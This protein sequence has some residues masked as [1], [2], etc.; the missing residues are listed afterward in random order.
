MCCT[1]LKRLL[2]VFRAVFTISDVVIL[3]AEASLKSSSE[4]PIKSSALSSSGCLFCGT[5][6][7]DSRKRTSLK[8]KVQDL[9]ERVAI[10]LDINISAIHVKQYL[11]NNRCYKKIKRLEKLQEEEKLLKTELKKSFASTNRFK[12]GIP[13]DSSLSPSTIAPTKSDCHNHDFHDQWTNKL[14]AKSLN[15]GSGIQEEGEKGPLLNIMP[16]DVLPSSRPPMIPAFIPVAA[17]IMSPYVLN[18]LVYL[19]VI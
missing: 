8:G 16:L 12:H 4:T 10:V 18:R 14:I 5:Q 2:A 9:A 15:F 6:Q 7:T 1:R 11:C 13:S 17:N 3:M 19:L